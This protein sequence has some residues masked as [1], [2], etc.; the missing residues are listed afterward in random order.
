MKISNIILDYSQGRIDLAKAKEITNE[1]LSKKFVSTLNLRN[2]RMDLETIKFIFKFLEEEKIYVEKID[3]CHNDFT[4][5]EAKQIAEFLE[6]NKTVK[7]ISLRHN[8]ID[9]E[10]L[11]HIIKALKNNITL[12]ELDVAYNEI[13]EV[14]KEL[15]NTLLNKLD[16]SSNNL[17]D[18]GAKSLAQ[19][20]KTNINLTD[21]NLRLCDIKKDGMSSISNS[22]CKNGTLKKLNL[23]HNSRGVYESMQE[24]AEMLKVNNKIQL[25]LNN[26]DWYVMSLEDSLKLSYTKISSLKNI[27]EYLENSLK[28]FGFRN[29][30]VYNDIFNQLKLSFDKNSKLLKEIDTAKYINKTL[31]LG[32]NF[33]EIDELS[34]NYEESQVEVTGNTE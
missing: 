11:E 3:L 21:L 23:H 26:F 15:S 29:D 18:D 34:K 1:L 7:S 4:S 5:K 2:T 28:N 24:I 8:K 16:L 14:T 10:G 22:L 27:K 12:E 20:L 25:T 13:T 32:N 9:S 30:D 17:G 31:G 6:K 19:F 33:Q